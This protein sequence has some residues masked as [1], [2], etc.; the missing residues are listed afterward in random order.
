MLQNRLASQT[1]PSAAPYTAR[2]RKGMV[3]QVQPKGSIQG[4]KS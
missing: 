3:S 4:A 1:S 2:A